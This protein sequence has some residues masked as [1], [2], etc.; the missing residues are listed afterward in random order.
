M[1]FWMKTVSKENHIYIEKVIAL[2]SQF[3]YTDVMINM[4]TLSVVTPPS[5]YHIFT[6]RNCQTYVNMMS[7]EGVCTRHNICRFLVY[8]WYWK[9]NRTHAIR[10][11]PQT[12]GRRNNMDKPEG[13][14]LWLQ[15]LFFFSNDEEIPKWRMNMTHFLSNSEKE[16]IR[17]TDYLN[18]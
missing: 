6:W 8:I 13:A 3:S 17:L 1:L 16:E 15:S 7:P 14:P 18:F 5:I 9:Y 4:K 2:S 11:A 12:R 10:Q